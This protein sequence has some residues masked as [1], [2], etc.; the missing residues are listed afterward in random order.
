MIRMLAL[1]LVGMLGLA[2]TG[3]KGPKIATSEVRSKSWVAAHC[4]IGLS[5]G[6][7]LV[8]E[9]PGSVR[10]ESR[11]TETFDKR[12]SN[13]IAVAYTGCELRIVDECRP[14]ADYDWQKTSVRRDTLEIQDA[15][16]LYAK[17]PLGAASLESVLKRSGRLTVMT[18]AT[19]QLKVVGS[20]DLSEV[21]RNAS[22]NLATHIVSAVTMGAFKTMATATATAT[23]TSHAPE[24]VRQAGIEAE[25]SRASTD[26]MAPSCQSPLQ[27]FL[28][29]IPRASAAPASGRF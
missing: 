24:I 25:C 11:L 22:C 29:P 23:A 14:R 19:G 27:V 15:D 3:A 1:S 28:V 9:W 16:A 18:T 2:C 10:L 17:L 6:E 7:P 4:A 5:H 8:T 21:S 13:A 20:I 26:M 12:D